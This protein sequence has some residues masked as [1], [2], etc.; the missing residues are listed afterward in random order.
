MGKEFYFVVNPPLIKDP[1]GDTDKPLTLKRVWADEKGG[2]LEYI[3]YKGELD[4][5]PVERMQT[6]DILKVLDVIFG[7]NT[8]SE[9]EWRKFRPV[10]RL[11][12]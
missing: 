8:W 11:A 2:H 10:E 12:S 1:W 4:Y 6:H 9:G 7:E 5:A 3:N